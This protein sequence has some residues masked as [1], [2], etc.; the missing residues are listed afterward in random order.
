MQIG[1]KYSKTKTGCVTGNI[2]QGHK[3]DIDIK[4]LGLKGR[5]M[6]S[7]NCWLLT[8][9]VETQ[10]KMK[11]NYGLILLLVKYFLAKEHFYMICFTCT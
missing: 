11:V 4:S 2:P 5:C 10:S 6:A 9:A 7:E 3:Y 8:G 1:K